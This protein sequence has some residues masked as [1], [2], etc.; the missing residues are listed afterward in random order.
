MRV[1]Q[2]VLGQEIPSGFCFQSD[3]GISFLRLHFGQIII[4]NWDG[5]DFVVF[6]MMLLRVPI[7]FVAECRPS[8]ERWVLQ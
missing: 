8:D 4:T 5:P 2:S 1:L 3:V 6:S 7:C